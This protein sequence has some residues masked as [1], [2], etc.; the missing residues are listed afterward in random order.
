V[1]EMLGK[2]VGNRDFF[3]S[4]AGQRLL[5]NEREVLDIDAMVGL[6]LVGGNG[7]VGS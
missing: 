1:R 2:E 6:S 4:Y 5:P 7:G 3:G